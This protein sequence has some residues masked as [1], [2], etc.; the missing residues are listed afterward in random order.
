M[1]AVLPRPDVT[2][3]STV[4]AETG[5]HETAITVARDGKQRTWSGS[6]SSA[7]ASTAEAVKKMLDDPITAEYVKEG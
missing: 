6:G 5:T 1:M 2:V 3:G 7:G 4:Q